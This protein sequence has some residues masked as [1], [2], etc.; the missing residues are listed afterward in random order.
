MTR[1]LAG[2]SQQGKPPRF[3][4]R[5]PAQ[6]RLIEQAEN[7]GVGANPKGNREN[8]N[9]REPRRP[10]QLPQSV[11]EILNQ[12]SHQS[13]L[14]RTSMPPWDRPWPLCGRVCSTRKEPPPREKWRSRQRCR[15]RSDSLPTASPTEL[16]SAATPTQCPRQ[17]PATAA[18]F[19]GRPQATK[20][21]FA[22]LQALCGFR[23]REFFA[24]RHKK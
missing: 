7:R 3:P 21:P 6:K 15:G 1:I 13:L 5:K 17:L 24:I 16:E 2:I 8:R 9:R 14:T 11:T 20:H 22:W 23:S 18:S 4:H 10:A 19:P 12:S